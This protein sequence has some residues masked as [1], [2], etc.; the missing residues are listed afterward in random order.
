[1]KHWLATASTHD[2]TV[3][4]NRSESSEKI[5]KSRF[6]RGQS[7]PLAKR[8]LDG[9][10]RNPGLPRGADAAPDFAALHPGYVRCACFEIDA[11]I[12]T[13]TLG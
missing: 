10:Q 9:A 11:A 3:T 13:S 2:V 8:S 6:L 1:M 5:R 4:G 7:M 12:G